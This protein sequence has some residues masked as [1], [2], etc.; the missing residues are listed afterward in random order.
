MNNDS[1]YFRNVIIDA[2]P[3][4]L[5]DSIVSPK[6]KT[7]KGERVGVRSL[8]CSILGVEGHVETSGWGLRRLTSKSI[9]HMDLHNPNKKLVNVE[10]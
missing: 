4:S 3:S 5:M 6:M 9:T 1:D 7:S 2:P 8:A 10:L